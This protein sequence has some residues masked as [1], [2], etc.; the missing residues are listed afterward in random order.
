MMHKL[1]DH[2]HTH[3]LFPTRGDERIFFMLLTVEK[4]K[5]V[6]CTRMFVLKG[7]NAF[8]YHICREHNLYELFRQ[9]TTT[10]NLKLRTC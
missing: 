8:L 2:T 1:Y 9:T 5:Y 7:I 6:M 10:V 3:R 4:I